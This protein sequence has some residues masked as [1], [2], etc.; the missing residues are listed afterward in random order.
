M[1]CCTPVK[2]IAQ[3]RHYMPS[4]YE[5]AKEEKHDIDHLEDVVV[6]TELINDLRRSLRS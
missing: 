2:W 1:E 5:K 6:A 4:A 3:K